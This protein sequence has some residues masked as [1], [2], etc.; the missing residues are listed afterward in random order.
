MEDYT[1]HIQH[2]KVYHYPNK[3]RLGCNTDG[4]YVIADISDYDCYISA[5]VSNEESFTRDFI[6]KYSMEASK[7]H[8]F[9]G[10]ITDYPWSYT[11]DITFYKKNIGHRNTHETT[12]LSFLTEKYNNIFLKMDIEGAEFP[13]LITLSDKQLKSFKQITLEVH[14]I[15]DEQFC[16]DYICKKRSLERLTD[17]HYLIHAHGNNNIQQVINGVPQTMELT[18]L[19]KDCFDL[20]PTLNTLPLPFPGLDICNYDRVPELDLNHYPFVHKL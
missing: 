4:G 6:N 18:Y 11:K 1:Q 19:R 2:L 9:D 20:P 10:T 5:G 15:N 17:F 12:N 8:A 14:F 7:N 3:I 16:S 13:W